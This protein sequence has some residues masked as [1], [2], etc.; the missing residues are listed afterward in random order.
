MFEKGGVL[1]LYTLGQNEA[2]VL[3]V[4]AQPLTAYVKAAGGAEAESV[5][6]A[7]EPQPGDKA[8]MTSQFVGRLPRELAG[9]RVEVTIPALRIGRER[10]PPRVS[11]GAPPR[12]TTGCRPK[13]ADADEQKLYLTAGGK[14]TAAD[15][16]ANGG[17]TAVAKFRGLKAEHDL[18]PKA[19]DLICPVTRTKA[20]AKFS[21]VVGGRAYQFCCPP[22]VDEFVALAKEK[23]ADIRPPDFYRQK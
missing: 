3:E 9:K 5:V 1:R 22:C 11:V 17:V 15:I 20:N 6:L 13:V 7:A 8:G 10:V 23:P 21:W 16:A 4:E 19:G 14:Y 12:P 18:K 2:V